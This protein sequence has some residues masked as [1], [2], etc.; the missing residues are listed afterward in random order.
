MTIRVEIIDVQPTVIMVALYYLVPNQFYLPVSND[1][2]RT[3]VGSGLDATD[4]ALLKEGRLFEL[5][6]TFDPAAITVQG[7]RR[8]VEQLWSDSRQEARVEYA[9]LYS[10]V[11]IP[12]VVGKVWDGS[13]WN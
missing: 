8:E 2:D 3:P 7:I 5:V 11:N 4:L 1:P 12:D 9:R 13:T 6:K 10:Y